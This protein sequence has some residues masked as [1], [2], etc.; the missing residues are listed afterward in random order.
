MFIFFLSIILLRILFAICILLWTNLQYILYLVPYRLTQ[1][2]KS[3]NLFSRPVLGEGWG[4]RKKR[5]FFEVF[6]LTVLVFKGH[7]EVFHCI[8]LTVFSIMPS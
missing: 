3:G 7:F 1:I 6:P 8:L 2:L 4:K 5:L